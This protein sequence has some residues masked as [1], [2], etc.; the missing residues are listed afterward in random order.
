MWLLNKAVPSA[1]STQSLSKSI[2]KLSKTTAKKEEMELLLGESSS[3]SPPVPAG[4]AT[5]KVTTV[6]AES[7]ILELND[8]D[9]IIRADNSDNST[10]SDE[11]VDQIIEE[12]QQKE[13]VRLSTNLLKDNSFLKVPSMTSWRAAMICV[14][15]ILGS[16]VGAALSAYYEKLTFLA[17]AVVGN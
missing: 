12:Y 15:A 4:S 7:S 11:D 5:K 3:S 8:N 13:K 17:F 6:N 16:S 10:D 1:I 2:S 9:C 14:I